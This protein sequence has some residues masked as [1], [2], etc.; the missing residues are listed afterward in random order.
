MNDD[1]SSKANPGFVLEDE[2]SLDKPTDNL[3]A[4]NE[5]PN[6]NSDGDLDNQTPTV[7]PEEK[8]TTNTQSQNGGFDPGVNPVYTMLDESTRDENLNISMNSLNSLKNGKGN[9]QFI[10]NGKFEEVDL[11]S[12][13][14]KEFD[15]D[16]KK[17]SGKPEKSPMQNA[18]FISKY[19]TFW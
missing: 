12:E 17:K 9:G 19:L 16:K 7:G 10:K 13:K 15:K 5:V 11:N 2:S 18:F 6:K 3:T 4:E 1:D 14:E 8:D